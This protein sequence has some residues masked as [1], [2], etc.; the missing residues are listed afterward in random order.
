[1]WKV[2]GVG[3]LLQATVE[4]KEM[5]GSSKDT[6]T[7]RGSITDIYVYDTYVTTFYTSCCFEEELKLLRKTVKSI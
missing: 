5:R 4:A 6:R 2:Q 1:M 7:Q 3:E